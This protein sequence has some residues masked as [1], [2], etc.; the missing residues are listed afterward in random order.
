MTGAFKR[1]M[2][3]IGLRF[4]KSACEGDCSCHAVPH[5]R[6]LLAVPD[7]GELGQDPHKY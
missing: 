4:V 1:F 7:R 6:D 3:F 5:V 2:A